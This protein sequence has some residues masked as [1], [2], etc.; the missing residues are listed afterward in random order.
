MAAS[1]SR[2]TC[3]ISPMLGA[4]ENV[5]RGA[6]A[7]RSCY[8][9][10]LGA[11]RLMSERPMSSRRCADQRS[12]EPK[13]QLGARRALDS[14]LCAGALPDP[15]VVFSMYFGPCELLPG[16]DFEHSFE[17]KTWRSGYGR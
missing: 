4:Y 6:P 1:A 15:N 17:M 3:K 8:R 14:T 5:R 12:S 7:M 13:K 9:T 11:S 16:C 2:A 10:T